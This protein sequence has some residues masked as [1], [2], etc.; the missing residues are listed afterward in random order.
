MGV[1]GE[2]GKKLDFNVPARGGLRI[3]ASDGEVVSTFALAVVE[4][5]L[6]RDRGCW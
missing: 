4:F 6:E 5:E 3:F 2:A 1:D